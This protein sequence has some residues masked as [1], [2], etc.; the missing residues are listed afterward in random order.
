MLPEVSL[1]LSSPLKPEIQTIETERMIVGYVYFRSEDGRRILV[2]HDLFLK[3]RFR[4]MG[5][6]SRFIDE[7]FDLSLFDARVSINIMSDVMFKKI[8]SN[9]EVRPIDRCLE[10][11]IEYPSFVYCQGTVPPELLVN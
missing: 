1:I 6:A 4:G 11:Q 5:L 10:Y 8:T 9:Y 2:V 7:T 3:K